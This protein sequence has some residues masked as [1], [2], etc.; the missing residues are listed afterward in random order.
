M[1]KTYSSL[2]RLL[3]AVGSVFDAYSVA[4]FRRNAEG[5]FD[6]AASFSLG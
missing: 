4:L 2:D 3:E 6:L 1:A 5:A